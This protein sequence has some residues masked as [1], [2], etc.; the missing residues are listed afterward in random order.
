LAR[1]AFS[2]YIRAY[3]THP[4]EEKKFFHPKSLHLGHLAKSFALREAPGALT[5]ATAKLAKST[6]RKREKGGQYNDHSDDD[7]DDDDEEEEGGAATATGKKSKTK[8]KDS[9]D[10]GKEKGKE[11]TARN[12]TERRM[13]EA[14]RK[15]TRSIRSEGKM[16]QFGDSEFQVMGGGDVER[17]VRR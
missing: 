10:S 17:M 14:V 11:S 6:K 5:S 16:G 9:G 13:Y 15:A 8:G 7:G 12:E 4:L 1:R 2:S 3:S